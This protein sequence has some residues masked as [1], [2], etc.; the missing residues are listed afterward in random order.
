VLVVDGS[1]SM[2][3]ALVGDALAELAVKNGWQV[4]LAGWSCL[5][6]PSHLVHDCETNSNNVSNA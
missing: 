1:G 5:K 4:R 2:R 3:C 6:Y